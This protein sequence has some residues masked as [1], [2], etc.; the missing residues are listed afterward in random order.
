MA[1]ACSASTPPTTCSRSEGAGAA[2]SSGRPRARIRHGLDSHV[3]RQRVARPARRRR[4][5]AD[6]DRPAR[7][8]HHGEAPRCRRLRGDGVAGCEQLPDEPVD[9]I[10]FSRGARVL[11]TIACDQPERFERLVLGAGA[12][13]VTTTGRWLHVRACAARATRRARPRSVVA[14]GYRL[15]RCRCCR[16]TSRRRRASPAARRVPRDGS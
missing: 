16:N 8:R 4:P 6:R 7:P 9:A 10:G 3:A 2:E 5:R 11:L 1:W 15:R 12:N 13:L 14:M